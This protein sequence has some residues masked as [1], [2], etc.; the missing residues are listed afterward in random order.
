PLRVD[1]RIGNRLEHPGL[2]RPD[3]GLAR[4]EMKLPEEQLVRSPAWREV[5][6]EPNVGRLDVVDAGKGVVRRRPPRFGSVGKHAPSEHLGG[7][8]ALRPAGRQHAD[9]R[10]TDGAA[11]AGSLFRKPDE[12]EW[13]GIGVVV[14]EGY[15][16]VAAPDRLLQAAVPGERDAGN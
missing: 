11:V 6:V 3:D 2:R 16:G 1:P 12:P 10:A 9:L 8:D 14:D 7:G 13:I 15:M 5:P 4:P